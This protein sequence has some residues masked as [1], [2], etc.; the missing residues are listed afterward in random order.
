[1]GSSHCG[2]AETNLTSIQEIVDRSLALLSGSGIQ[3]CR[4]LWQ[5]PPQTLSPCGLGGAVWILNL[6]AETQ[7]PEKLGRL[8]GGEE[9]VLSPSSHDPLAHPK[10][11][12]RAAFPLILTDLSSPLSTPLVLWGWEGSETCVSPARGASSPW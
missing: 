1:M 4:E 12:V 2:S 8:L 9:G 3:W 6:L 11:T 7:C 10:V 5:L